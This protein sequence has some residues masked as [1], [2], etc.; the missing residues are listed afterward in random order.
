MATSGTY[1]F[2]ETRD[3]IITNALSLIG[4]IGAGETVTANDTTLAASIL[5]QMVKAWMA[6]GIHLWKQEEGTIYFVNGQNS[7]NL[8]GANGG[9]GSGTPVETALAS[10]GSG[11]SITVTTGTGAN[12]SANDNIGIQLDSNKIYW[13]TISGAPSGDT[14]TLAGT[15]PSAAASGNKV[16]TY[17]TAIPRPLSV[18]NLRVMS[19]SGFETRVWLKTRDEFMMIPQKTLTSSIP[20]V[21][22]YSPQLTTG[23]LYLWPTP[24]DVSYRLKCTYLRTIQDFDASGDNPDFPQEHLECL[25]Y[26]LAVRLAPAFGINLS[27]GGI[28]GNPD[29][30]R[31]AAQYLEDLKAWDTEEPYVRVVP[32]YRYNRDR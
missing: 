31:Q 26:N 15:I 8:P 13:T 28:Q 1:T 16:F 30:L 7:Y 22:Y 27:S 24:S 10:A 25:V 21:G 29:I 5:N 11:S 12:M 18:T 23:V 17:T 32:N 4:A 2:N 9:D 14:I 19:G 6:Q 20:T 3:Q